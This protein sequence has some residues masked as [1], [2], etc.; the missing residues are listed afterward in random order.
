[1]SRLDQR[2]AA[3]RD[4]GRK[5]LVPYVAAGDPAGQ[6][7]VE[8]LHALAAAG[9]DVIE[10]GVPFSDP[11]ADGP[12]VAQ[13]CERALAA[14]TRLVDVLDMVARFR[15]RDTETPIVLMGYLNP[16]ESMGYE[17]FAESARDAGVDGVLIVDLTPEEAPDVTPALRAAGLAPIFLAA[18]NTSLDRLVAIGREA[19]GY[20]Y[21]VSLKG[22][23]GSSRLDTGEV[24]ARVDLLQAHTGIP[25]LV[26]FGIRDAETAATI[27]STAD[28]VVIGS[29]LIQALVDRGEQSAVDAATAFLAPIRAAMDAGVKTSGNAA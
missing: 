22:V 27:A 15:E 14:G 16:I 3:V 23:T 25:V 1:M 28:G 17:R 18:P 26:G 20:L 19:A 2:L 13:A 29:A 7:T 11:M 8:L 6:N 21:Y 24:A 4:A 10:L 5:S 9:A 12:T